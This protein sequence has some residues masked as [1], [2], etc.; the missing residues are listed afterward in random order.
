MSLENAQPRYETPANE[1]QVVN[2]AIVQRPRQEIDETTWSNSTHAN[3]SLPQCAEAALG[4]TC[5]SHDSESESESES[6]MEDKET[7]VCVLM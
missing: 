5:P 2:G 1:R 7:S 4:G 6:V 3:M